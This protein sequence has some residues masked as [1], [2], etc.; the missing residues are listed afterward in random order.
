MKGITVRAEHILRVENVR[1]DR[2]SRCRLDPSDW[3]MDS[4]V[5]LQIFNHWGPL[6]VNLFAA[7]HNAQLP[8]YFSFKLD[9]G[10]VAVDEL[11]SIDKHLGFPLIPWAPVWTPWQLAP[12]PVVE[13]SDSIILS[14]FGSLIGLQLDPDA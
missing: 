3:R 10:A 11:Q 1:A 2:E 7:R 14:A 8:Q 6:Q 4:K 13:A 12:Q 9:P 5:F